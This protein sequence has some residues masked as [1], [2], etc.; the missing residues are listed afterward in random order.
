[1]RVCGK[2]NFIGGKEVAHNFAV[3]KEKLSVAP[4][5]ALPSFNKLFEAECVASKVETEVVLSQEKRPI[6]FFYEKLCDA[7]WKWS[8]YNQ[9]Y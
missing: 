1:M 5:L 4:A 6:A 9:E 7:C 3:I 2:K 8:S